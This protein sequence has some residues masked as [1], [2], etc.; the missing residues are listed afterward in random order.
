[1]CD[2]VM[3]N[4]GDRSYERRKAGAADVEAT[5]AQYLSSGDSETITRL[6]S[7]IAVNFI[8]SANIFHRKGGLAALAAAAKALANSLDPYLPLI[9]GP[10]LRCFED[11]EVRPRCVLAPRC[12]LV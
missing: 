7:F 8:G 2:Q 3:R 4:L 1:M 10:I 6:V 5:L 12:R 11:S 9:V